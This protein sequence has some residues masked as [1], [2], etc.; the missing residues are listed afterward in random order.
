M[1]VALPE[2]ATRKYDLGFARWVRDN[3]NGGAKMSMCMQCGMCSGSCPIGT[4]MDQGPRKLFMMI[5]AGMKDEV[6]N[7]STIWN[8]T[9]CYN[10]T[11]RCPRGVPVTYIIQDL[12]AKAVE[13]GYVKKVENARFAKAFWW[14][15]K[16]FGRTDERLMTMKYYYSGGLV[17]FVRKSLANLSI[18]IGMVRTKRMHIGMPH[19]IK[20]T[21]GLQAILAKAAEIDARESK[22]GA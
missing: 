2:Q 5:R 10:C 12:A 1:T 22:G 4:E 19:K 8:C 6:F 14:S 20:D 17:D 9:S 15:A 21:K 18:A 13:F 11:V 3:V 7:S 16:T